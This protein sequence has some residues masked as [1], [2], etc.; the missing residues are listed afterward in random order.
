[1]VA[2]PEYRL[3]LFLSVDL[4]G[5]TAFKAKFSEPDPEGSP[6]PV[7]VTV[8]QHFYREFPEIFS[9]KYGL[10][11][12]HAEIAGLKDNQPIVWK[13]IGD[14]IVFCCRLLSLEH[15]SLLLKSFIKTLAEYGDYL[16]TNH[17]QLDV[18][19][20]GWVA[21]FPSPNVTVAIYKGS[22]GG[23]HA[24]DSPVPNEADEL[25]ADMHPRDY[26]FLGK[27]I[28]SGFRSGRLCS[29]DSF[30]MPLEL[31]YLALHAEKAQILDGVKFIYL[32]RQML[33]GVLND[34]PYP[35]VALNVERKKAERRCV[36]KKMLCFPMVIGQRKCRFVNFWKHLCMMKA[37]QS[38]Y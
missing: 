33:K 20:N 28:D 7:W 21:D 34:R 5:S 35:I 24:A 26:D 15:V 1:M 16:D 29:S 27:S 18:K 22:T 4:V 30:V 37:S 2:C 19:G 8:I 38:Q 32:G 25:K 12:D 9:R 36:K 3:R 14:E 31:A 10:A 13:T 6:N 23:D 17:D 11:V